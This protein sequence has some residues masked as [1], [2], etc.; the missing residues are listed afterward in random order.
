MTFIAVVVKVWKKYCGELEWGRRSAFY[1]VSGQFNSTNAVAWYSY[2]EER[3]SHAINGNYYFVGCR[4][5]G[6]LKMP[7]IMM[8]IRYDIQS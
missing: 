7:P 4:D 1:F 3:L 8:T 2:L 6:N 5:L